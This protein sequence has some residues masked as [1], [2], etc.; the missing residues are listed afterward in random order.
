MSGRYTSNSKRTARNKGSGTYHASS[1]SLDPGYFEGG[2]ARLRAQVRRQSRFDFGYQVYQPE[3]EFPSPVRN[4]D[5]A[6]QLPPRR[7]TRKSHG[8]RVVDTS[9]AGNPPASC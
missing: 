1:G 8:W 5:N 4:E 7:R 6:K 9:R 2:G 3:R